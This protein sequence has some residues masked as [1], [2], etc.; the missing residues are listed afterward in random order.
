M[1]HQSFMISVISFLFALS[2]AF[3]GTW[4]GGGGDCKW[5]NPANWKNNKV[6]EAGD[7]DAILVDPS[8]DGEIELDVDLTHERELY[9]NDDKSA[10]TAAKVRLT[11]TGKLTITTITTAVV[12]V[13]ANAELVIDGPEIRGE[14]GGMRV[15][16]GGSLEMRSG[17]FWGASGTSEL[18]LRGR[19]VINGGRQIHRRLIRYA[20]S[21]TVLNG[22]Y[23]ESS[24]DNGDLKS[25]AGIVFNGG[26]LVQ[27]DVVVNATRENLIPSETNA[28]LVIKNDSN[29]ITVLETP[30]TNLRV[31]GS[32][33]Q[34]NSYEIGKR[35]QF[36]FY[37]TPQSIHGRGR[38]YLNST[39]LR[40]TSGE[41]THFDLSELNTSQFQYGSS[42][43][44]IETH[45]GL[46]LG[47]F[48]GGWSWGSPTFRYNGLLELN[49]TDCFDGT[50]P[51]TLSLQNAYPQDAPALRVRGNGSLSLTLAANAMSAGLFSA[52]EVED[53]ATLAV[54]GGTTVQKFEADVVRVGGGATLSAQGKRMTVKSMT[55]AAKIAD[56]A[57]VKLAST[58]TGLR[59][60]CHYTLL[61]AG[62]W[63]DLSGVSVDAT[64]VPSGWRVVQ[65]RGIAYLTDDAEYEP[66][67]QDETKDAWYWLGKSGN[68]SDA[69]NWNVNS[70]NKDQS[71]YPG[72]RTGMKVYFATPSVAQSVVTNDTGATLSLARLEFANGCGPVCFRGD[73]IELTRSN[74]N[75]ADSAFNA[76]GNPVMPITFETRVISRQA[77]MFVSPMFGSASFLGGVTMDSGRFVFN[78][79]TR[80]GGTSTVNEI[81][82]YKATSYDG[83]YGDTAKLTLVTG[84]VVTV[85][86]QATPFGQAGTFRIGE[87]AT[88]AFEDGAVDF[89][90]ATDWGVRGLVDFGA[91]V[92]AFGTQ[93]FY[94]TG[95]VRV[96]SVRSCA[97]GAGVIEI[98]EGLRL[99]PA[100]WTTVTAASPANP[101]T[102]CLG[103]SA[104][105]G[106]RGDWTYGPEAGAAAATAA[107]DRALTTAGLYA[108]LTIDTEDPSTG[109]GHTITFAD[110]ILAKGDV[111]KKGAGTLAFAT[112][113]NRI[114]GRFTVEDGEV[115]LG[116]D[117]RTIAD[118]TDV[119]T[120]ARIDGIG[121]CVAQGFRAKVIDNG[122]G[123]ST[124]QMKPRG[125]MVLIFR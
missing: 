66:V 109:V 22:G 100:A 72:A 29:A 49:T 112:T 6:P 87:G 92:S 85:A 105:V 9:L 4:L 103:S 21:E 20:G 88:L 28:T 93:K 51:Q 17:S 84:A 47:S 102:I 40:G 89:R 73:P 114:D 5:S 43:N 45:N 19:L 113:G 58:D 25:G 99:E 13:P 125:G 27:Q 70:N 56:T 46:K 82:P 106:A 11:G 31:A 14:A 68:W 57:M 38:M 79:D 16:A 36:L 104:T 26:T 101:V 41:I 94:G 60:G 108:K 123:T 44:I 32:L 7:G 34:T 15:D 61:D 107:A 48:A 119:V 118:W 78:G 122:D 76:R 91:P 35:Q 116:G 111:V 54:S 52:L 63:G 50:T 30:N 53:G 75:S 3:A 96:S 33:F 42:G 62:P 69:A 120:A 77:T 64:G 55:R 110:P 71:S 80:L 115:A 37:T 74:V 81:E 86:A 117:L 90:A 59:S 18:S 24:L 67:P 2:S 97:E 8:Y 12:V 23:L 98:G 10:G 1:K 65:D 95:T 39:Y 124:L 83:V 121:D